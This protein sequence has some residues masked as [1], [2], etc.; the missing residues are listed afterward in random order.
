MGDNLYNWHEWDT[1]VRNEFVRRLRILDEKV[2]DPAVHNWFDIENSNDFEIFFRRARDSIPELHPRFISRSAAKHYADVMFIL[3]GRRI[4]E[5]Q[6]REIHFDYSGR[7]E[8]FTPEEAAQLVGLLRSYMRHT[9]MLIEMGSRDYDA[10]LQ[11]MDPQDENLKL[12]YLHW[13][14]RIPSP[15]GL[16]RLGYHPNY[17]ENDPFYESLRP[18][19]RNAAPDPPPERRRRRDLAIEIPIRSSASQVRS[20]LPYVETQPSYGPFPQEGIDCSFCADTHDP[21]AENGQ[22]ICILPCGHTFCVGEM[23]RYAQ[24]MYRENHN[25]TCPNCRSTYLIFNA[26]NE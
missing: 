9:S 14:R 19:R 16:Y 7:L 6:Y 17:R 13:D 24:Q 15:S 1:F 22:Q 3:S 10:A 11:V 26:D 18:Q 20:R 25:V 4:R 5:W 8:P 2:S 23:N 21:Y 12:F